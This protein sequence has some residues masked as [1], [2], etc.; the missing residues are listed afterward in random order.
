LAGADRV[1]DLLA[2]P[3][4]PQNVHGAQRAA[5]P[6]R[7]EIVLENVSFEYDPGVPVLEDVSLEIPAQASVA[8]VGRP[9][10]ASR[11]SPA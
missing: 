6:V 3:R 5:G 8:L 10:W 2:E 4:E 1:A 9:A 7:G 11:R